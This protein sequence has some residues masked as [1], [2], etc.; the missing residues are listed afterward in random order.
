M[1]DL[2]RT[3]RDTWRKLGP[4]KYEFRVGLWGDGEWAQ[5]LLDGSAERVR[6]QPAGSGKAEG[7]R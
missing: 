2:S 5:I 4:D 6:P 1:G 3:M 7:A